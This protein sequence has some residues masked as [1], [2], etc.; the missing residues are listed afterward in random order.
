MREEGVFGEIT[1]ALRR[2]F[3]DS[4]Y[5][6]FEEFKCAEIGSELHFAFHCGEAGGIAA[7]AGL[8]GLKALE[9]CDDISDAWEE[10]D[11]DFLL[12]ILNELMERPNQEEETYARVRSAGIGWD[13][14]GAA[15]DDAIRSY[16]EGDDMR[17]HL[18]CGFVSGLMFNNP[19]PRYGPDDVVR[20]IVEYH[21]ANHPELTDGLRDR[22]AAALGTEREELT[23]RDGIVLGWR[24]SCR[25]LV[26]WARAGIAFGVRM[27]SPSGGVSGAAA[28]RAYEERVRTMRW[29][30]NFGL[31]KARARDGS[32][33]IPNAMTVNYWLA[34][35]GEE[36]LSEPEWEEY[37]IVTFGD[38]SEGDE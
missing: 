21:E 36:E 16:D 33:S 31:R 7:A 10:D 13:A 35:G 6:G 37:E 9:L 23:L 3:A 26:D 1:T 19:G 28:E 27:S 15:L 12:Y 30:Q 34:S 8:F 29:A 32:V 22:V 18:M 11:N 2:A 20:G 14:R 24:E 5:A 38:E 25:E 4:G 17:Y